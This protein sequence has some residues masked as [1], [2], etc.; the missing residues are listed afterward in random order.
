MIGKHE[1][2][3]AEL[4]HQFKIGLSLKAANPIF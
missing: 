4:K 3:M 1:Q 2:K